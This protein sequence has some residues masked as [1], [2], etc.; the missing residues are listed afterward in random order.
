MI[1]PFLISWLIFHFLVKFVIMLFMDGHFIL[2]L[3]VG[4]LST[5][6]LSIL[7]IISQSNISFSILDLG[8]S[9]ICV[10]DLCWFFES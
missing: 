1:F 9:R 7:F 8:E 5:C 6:Q 10:F 4:I 2:P 3:L